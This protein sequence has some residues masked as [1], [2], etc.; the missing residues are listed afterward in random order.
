MCRSSSLPTGSD[1]LT[2]D[3]SSRR[4]AAPLPDTLWRQSAACLPDQVVDQPGTTTTRRRLKPAEQILLA[5]R[6]PLVL[7]KR[8]ACAPPA[9]SLARSSGGGRTWLRGPVGVAPK[10]DQQVGLRVSTLGRPR[11]IR[12]RAARAVK[13]L[14]VAIPGG[15][16]GDQLFVK[17]SLLTRAGRQVPRVDEVVGGQLTDVLGDVLIAVGQVDRS[18]SRQLG[19]DRR[20]RLIRRRLGDGFRIVAEQ[21][22]VER[23]ADVADRLAVDQGLRPQ[24]LTNHVIH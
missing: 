14:S 10:S 3:A 7:A 22:A 23:I 17:A 15:H 24:L 21:V 16:L 20:Q 13:L 19:S 11:S 18:A 1:S 6:T 9:S 2:R 8:W 5:M 12:H 4:N